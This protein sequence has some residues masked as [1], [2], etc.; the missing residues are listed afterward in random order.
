[1]VGTQLSTEF[2][3]EVNVVTA[4]YMPEFGRSTGG[5]LNV[6]T[7]S[8]SQRVPRR[9]LQLRLAR[10]PRGQAQSARPRTL[11]RVF[12]Q[13]TLSYIGDIGFDLGGPDHQGQALVLRAA[14]TSPA[15]ATTSTAAS[16]A[17]WPTGAIEHDARSDTP[18]LRG[19][20]PHLPG[21][22]QADLL[23]QRR[24]PPHPV[25]LR[26]AHQLGRRR[27]GSTA[28]TSPPAST[29]SIRC[30]ATPRAAAPAPT[31]PAPT[32]ISSTPHRRLAQVELA[33]PGQE[34]AARRDAG[35]P[36]PAR[37]APRR[38]RLDGAVEFAQRA[39]LLLQRQLAPRRTTR[40]AT[41]S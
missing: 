26:H 7:K 17:R 16:T 24:Q 3:E 33:V 2:V 6:V 15:P 1:M 14:S 40:A 31:A 25:G 12:A 32:S 5:V 22:R 13:P 4:G 36:L 39:R 35:H 10:R 38:R 41:T 19:R 34:A 27:P 8:G 28:P 30:R 20:G 29:A 9:R 18:G 21:H 37:F 23:G 11:T